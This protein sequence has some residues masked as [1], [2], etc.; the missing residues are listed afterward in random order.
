TI[1][2]LSASKPAVLRPGGITPQQIE[3][4]IGCSVDASQHK[5]GAKETPKAPGMKYK[6][7]AP[8]A[9]VL[10][11][12]P[13]DWQQALD[14]AS[15][16]GEK[17]GVM[18]LTKTLNTSIPKNVVTYDMGGDLASATH[19]L[20]DGLRYF[21]NEQKVNWILACSF[22]EKGL[23]AAYMNRLKKSSGDSYFEP[24]A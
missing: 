9:Q 24:Q 13:N 8:A 7:Y 19:R 14:W 12:A 18:A 10:I 5:V 15:K 17:V 23:G 6:H 11:V 3:A 4:V 21:D 1:I 22:E 2:D 20:F 16:Q